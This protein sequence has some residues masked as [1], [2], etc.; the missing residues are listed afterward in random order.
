M[1]R[2]ESGKR[3]PRTGRTEETTR[4]HG[5]HESQKKQWMR[6]KKQDNRRLGETRRGKGAAVFNAERETNTLHRIKTPQ[7]YYRKNNE[8][9]EQNE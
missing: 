6:A 5:K 4:K 9:R 2:G 8:D 3:V 1:D 7:L